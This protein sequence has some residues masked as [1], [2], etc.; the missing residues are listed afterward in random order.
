MACP[1]DA[2][3][4]ANKLPYG[5]LYT[6]ELYMK[7]MEIRQAFRP[8]ACQILGSN[9]YRSSVPSVLYSE[10]YTCILFLG[11][12]PGVELGHPKVSTRVLGPT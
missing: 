5:I 6:L 10:Q 11:G 9:Y 1:K 12:G 8:R 3:S 7:E 2:T 4:K